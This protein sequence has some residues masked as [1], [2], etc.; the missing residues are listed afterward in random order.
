MHYHFTE[1]P[2]ENDVFS[3]KKRQNYIHIMVFQFDNN[4]FEIINTA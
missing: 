1:N 3:P 2:H 4:T